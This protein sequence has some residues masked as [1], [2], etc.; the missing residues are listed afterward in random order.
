MPRSSLCCTVVDRGNTPLHGA[1][2]VSRG[3]APAVSDIGQT[4]I[5][6]SAAFAADG[7]AV[8]RVAFVGRPFVFAC[9]PCTR[10]TPGRQR[11][12]FNSPI[13]LRR[14]W[15]AIECLEEC[16]PGGGDCDRS[17]WQ[18]HRAPATRSR[19]PLCT[20]P[21]LPRACT[22]RRRRAR[23]RHFARPGEQVVAPGD[24][25]SQASMPG[26][27]IAAA[28]A[29]HLKAAFEPRQHLPGGNSFRFA[30]ASSMASGNP[31][32]RR[33]RS[34]TSCI[35]SGPM[36]KAGSTARARSMNRVSASAPSP[37]LGG[38][39]TADQGSAREAAVQRTAVRRR[40]EGPRGW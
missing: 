11:V 17:A 33:H 13:R 24:R 31:S 39:D 27:A 20:R 8:D 22:R 6:R 21:P 14:A 32:S 16:P 30:A 4:D 35:V 9:Q 12:R 15:R 3:L 38:P 5:L 34:T 36:V 19:T 23:E 10:A 29:K 2:L 1:R 18:M 28:T 7:L 25:G 26:R 40:G 37:F